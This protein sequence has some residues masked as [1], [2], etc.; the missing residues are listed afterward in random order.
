[1][2]ISWLD[3]VADFRLFE[4]GPV[5]VTAGKI[6]LIIG[7]GLALFL[8][9][10]VLERWLTRRILARRVIDAGVVH[11]VSTII[12]YVVF[13]AGVFVV[14]ETIGVDLSAIVVVLGTLGL[15]IGL[16]IQPLLTNFVSGIVLLFERSIRVGDRIEI[17]SL[18]GD[19]ARISMR[20]TT[21][22]TNDS[23]AVVVPN[24]LLAS[25]QI[26]NWSYTGQQVRIRIPVGVSYRSD[27]DT[28]TKVLLEVAA[29][30]PGVLRDPAPD[31]LFDA[32]GESALD[33]VLRISTLAFAHR[34]GVIRSELNFAIHRAFREHGIEIPFPQ[35]DVHIRKEE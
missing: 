6:A 12:R 19:V 8:G 30:H 4:V 14:L 25:S 11:A 16:A 22:V 10:R 29:N 15:G 32:F 2:P 35:R 24:G 1:M 7:L 13:G 17:G 20:S 33:F 28:V 27:P 3:E 34:P 18:V 5:N 9:L 21:V 26:V 31:V 23:I